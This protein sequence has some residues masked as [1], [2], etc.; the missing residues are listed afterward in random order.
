MPKGLWN[1]THPLSALRFSVCAQHIL[2]GLLSYKIRESATT[3]WKKKSCTQT[4]F[5]GRHLE[6]FMNSLLILSWP[7][8]K[9]HT[10]IRMSSE[11]QKYSFFFYGFLKEK[12]N[13]AHLL[14][15]V[16]VAC[17][18]PIFI[19]QMFSKA[20]RKTFSS[21]TSVALLTPFRRPL[22]LLPIKK[23]AH[24]PS[25][26]YHK[27]ACN[28]MCGTSFLKPKFQLSTASTIKEK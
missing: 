28:I 12:P 17:L 14:W 9:H 3:K 24:F 13:R 7:Y 15:I 27:A 25:A 23:H 11:K 5:K 19:S 22:I 6:H 2:Y 10:T 8:H 21:V 20:K 26:R 18:I 16:S 4:S 1:Q